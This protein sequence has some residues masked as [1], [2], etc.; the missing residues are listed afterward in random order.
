MKCLCYEFPFSCVIYG[1]TCHYFMLK[2]LRKSAAR[3]FNKQMRE[4]KEGKVSDK[5][6]KGK[7]V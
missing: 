1:E 6:K 4:K 5:H 3:S 7:S 2:Y